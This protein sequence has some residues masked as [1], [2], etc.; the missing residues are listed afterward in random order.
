MAVK[1]PPFYYICKILRIYYNFGM[2][3]IEE[4]RRSRF[5]RLAE[6]RTE[7]VLNMID[8][9][10]NLS[11]KS[12]YEYTDEEVRAI[13]DAIEASLK[14]NKNKFNKNNKKKRRF[15]L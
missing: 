12:F 10:G 8:L 9:I 6:A 14:E 15:T 3:K 11:N 2:G 7:K 5:K 4:N 1:W 13:F